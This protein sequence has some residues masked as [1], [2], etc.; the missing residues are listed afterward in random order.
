L[1][2]DEQH[3]VHLQQFSKASLLIYPLTP[4]RISPSAVPIPKL[5]IITQVTKVEDNGDFRKRF[6]TVHPGSKLLFNDKSLNVDFYKVKPVTILFT[7]GKEH[8]ATENIDTEQYSKA[9]PDIIAKDSGSIINTINDKQGSLLHLLTKEYG[10][11]EV[12]KDT[13]FMYWCDSLGFNILGKSVK[14]DKWVDFR[15]PFD[16]QQSN[17][18]ETQESIQNS[19]S[20]LK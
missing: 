3:A 1:A 4:Q 10:G 18:Q 6:E 8:G 9:I 11:I 2:D 7:G 19:I 15:I 17:L 13:T 16:N 5:N 20:S 14:E 12:Q